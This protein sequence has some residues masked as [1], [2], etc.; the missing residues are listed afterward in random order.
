MNISQELRNSVIGSLPELN[1]IRDESLRA[2]VV[3]AWAYSL[4]KS[5][6]KSIDEIRPSGNPDTP[7][8]KTGTQTDHIRGVTQLAIAIADS[9]AK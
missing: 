5:S 9:M 2:K 4:G 1:E 8:M 6:F 3:D 7:G